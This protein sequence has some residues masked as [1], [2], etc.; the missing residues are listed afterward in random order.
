V[1]LEQIGEDVRVHPIVEAAR[2]VAGHGGLHER[3]ERLEGIFAPPIEKRLLH[4]PRPIGVQP[5]VALDAASLVGGV[6]ALGLR[7]RVDPVQ[8]RRRRLRQHGGKTG[9]R[10]EC[11]D[12]EARQQQVVRF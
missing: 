1:G 9:G 7:R 12:Q 6:T 4:Q 11:S 10:N 2:A 3:E 8:D 5:L